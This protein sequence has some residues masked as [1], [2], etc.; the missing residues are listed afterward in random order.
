VPMGET[1]QKIHEFE[2]SGIHFQ[3]NIN[4]RS[5][6]QITNDEAEKIAYL[7][8][9]AWQEKHAASLIV[10]LFSNVVGADMYNLMAYSAGEPD[11]DLVEGII[12]LIRCK[13][14][15]QEIYG[16]D[17]VVALQNRWKFSDE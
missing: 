17:Y 1:M 8:R 2:K 3:I 15:S 4:P 6:I 11:D 14:E 9:L 5:D 16:Q 10:C 7:G 12:A 13:C